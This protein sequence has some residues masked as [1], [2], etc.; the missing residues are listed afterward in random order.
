[1]IG[2]LLECGKC[3]IG[4]GYELFDGFEEWVV[5][6]IFGVV[7]TTSTGAR[8]S[9][10]RSGNFILDLRRCVLGRHLIRHCAFIC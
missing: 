10:T 4:D 7:G 6:I 9:R 5:A 2:C 3:R 8:R 1:M